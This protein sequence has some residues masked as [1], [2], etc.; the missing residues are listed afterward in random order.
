MVT[1]STYLI[2]AMLIE[3]NFTICCYARNSLSPCWVWLLKD[4]NSEM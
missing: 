4:R 1:N 3:K 2:S